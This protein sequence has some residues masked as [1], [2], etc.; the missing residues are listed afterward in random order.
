[1]DNDFRILSISFRSADSYWIKFDSSKVTSE[2]IYQ[3]LIAIQMFDIL[4]K[5][6]FGCLL[7]ACIIDD[8]LTILREWRERERKY[9]TA[10][11][12]LGWL[13]IK[14]RWPDS[15]TTSRYKRKSM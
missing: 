1:V 10:G 6:F 15:A 12:Q 11:F 8:S 5:R 7:P 14:K 2:F 4:S 13:Q 3:R 9:V